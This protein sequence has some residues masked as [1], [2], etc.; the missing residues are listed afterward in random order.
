[1]SLHKMFKRYQKQSLNPLSSLFHHGLIRILLLSQ[2][3]DTWEVFLCRNNFAL[4]KNTVDPPLLSNPN[5]CNPAIKDLRVDPQK[6]HEI[7]DRPS[8]VVRKP[9]GQ[10]AMM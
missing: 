6:D 7:I 9:I 1:M 5:P 10:K 2:I 3:G 4:P 8:V